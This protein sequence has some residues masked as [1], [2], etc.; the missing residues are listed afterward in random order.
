MPAKVAQSLEADI[1]QTLI[2]G[3][4]GTSLDPDIERLAR[5][6]RLG[7]AI[8][9]RRNISDF[10]QVRALNDEIHALN[11]ESPLMIAVDQEGGRVQRLR[12][13]F[14]ELPPMRRFGEVGRKSLTHRAGGLLARALRVLGF[15]QNYAPVLDVDSNP[16]NPVIGDRAFSSDPHLVSRLGA[17]FIDGLQSEGVAA[18]GKHFPGHGDTDLDSHLALPR[19]DHDLER[20]HAVEWP[21][22]RAA[23]RVE[24]AALM[25]AHVVFSAIDPTRPA[26][27]SPAVIRPTLRD[28]IRFDG[29]IVSDDLEM[30]SIADHK[31]VEVAAVEALAAG[32]DQ[33]LICHHPPLVER[34][35]EAILAAVRD[36]R[37]DEGQVR[38]SASRVRA[39]KTR[40]V[41]V[42]SP[43]DDLVAAFPTRDYENLMAELGETGSLG[44]DPTEPPIA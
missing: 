11:P 17:A 10:D 31:A 34:A 5:R 1:G 8:L 4:Q 29:V 23:A 44:R 40:Y 35:F 3:F 24:V 22:F 37:L 15:D 14:P 7:G 18:C 43:P 32:C 41:R 6:G 38:A 2:A 9:F 28:D 19:I 25:S 13:P 27:L 39:L 20:L 16:D 12:A 21:P 42:D 26:T 36:G 30:K 33:L